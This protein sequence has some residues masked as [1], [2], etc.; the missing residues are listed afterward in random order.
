[1]PSNAPPLATLTVLCCA[2]VVEGCAVHMNM[3]ILYYSYVEY[4]AMATE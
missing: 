4:A 2:K 1:M 3:N